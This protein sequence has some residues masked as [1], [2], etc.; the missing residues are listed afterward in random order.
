MGTDSCRRSQ[1][2]KVSRCEG[3][4]SRF[5]GPRLCRDN[6]ND[7]FRPN[8]RLD[9]LSQRASDCGYVIVRITVIHGVRKN[10]FSNSTLDL[11][12]PVVFLHV[13]MQIFIILPAGITTQLNA[14]KQVS[15][16]GPPFL[17]NISVDTSVGVH[18]FGS[19]RKLSA[20]T[21]FEPVQTQHCTLRISQPGRHLSR[22]ERT[23]SWFEVAIQ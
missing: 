10:A 9:P 22:L 16:S 20:G 2:E 8:V 7:G 15:N 17:N 4:L 19:Q 23:F 13:S 21:T 11:S 1:R 6:Q 3:L 14:N 5:D 18:F 12:V